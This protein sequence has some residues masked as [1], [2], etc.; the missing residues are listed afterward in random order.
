MNKTSVFSKTDTTTVAFETLDSVRAHWQPDAT[1]VAW[2]CPF[3]LP[4]WLKAWWR[5]FGRDEDLYLI[6]VRHEHRTI[7]LAPLLRN[8]QS[9]RLM[10]DR[11]VCD[12]LD[13]IVAPGRAAE[14]YSTLFHQLKQDGITRL[15]LGLMRPDSSAYTE[16]LPEARKL[17]CRVFC[18]PA[19]TSYELKLPETWNAYL[20]SLGGKERHEVRRKLR[21]LK[22][23]GK[24]NFRL[25]DDQS[26]A[27]REMEV[28]LKL[29]KLNRPDKAAFMSD[30]M[31]AFFRDLAVHLAA[32]GLL[33]LYFLDLDEKPIAAVMCFDYLSTRYLYNKGYDSRYS[34]LSAGLLSKVLSIKE[35]F[36]TGI[37]T[38]DFLKGAEAY[39]RRL[40]GQPISLY[41]CLLE[42][43]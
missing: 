26:P 5:N 22:R 38:Y 9:A 12:N 43:T 11:N 1:G 25:A 42:F 13:F 16:L 20:D 15:E 24:V 4:M 32:H 23:A 37:K 29:F 28:F 14:F 41:Q 35:S 34:T 27:A 10:G 7:G 2:D 6:S 30:K 19:A 3:V 40:G 8:T 17:G 31:G 39:K 21:R 36:Q 33:K 18:Q